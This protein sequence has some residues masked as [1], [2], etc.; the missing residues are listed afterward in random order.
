MKILSLLIWVTQFGVSV[1]VPPCF[2]LWLASWAQNTWGVGNWIY[3]VCGLLGLLVS[4]NVACRN[5]DM[6]QKEVRKSES[7]KKDKAFNDH[8]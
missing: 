1:V 3:A 5:L 6:M 7:N 8:E 4:W 2:F